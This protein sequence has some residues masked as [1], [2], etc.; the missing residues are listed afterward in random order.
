MRAVFLDT[1]TFSSQIPFSNIA[2]QLDVLECFPITQPEDVIKRC[3]G[4]DVVITNKVVLT[5]EIISALPDLKLIC[6]AATGTNNVDILSAKAQ[7]VAVTNAAGYA[8]PS[9]AQYIMAQ[10]LNYYQNI[11]HHHKN[12]VDGLWQQSETFCFLGNPIEEL[13][14]KH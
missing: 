7:G 6:V 14:G 3:L 8:G 12:V 13:S 10:L 4:F 1:Q 2:K 9:V 5:D 11:H